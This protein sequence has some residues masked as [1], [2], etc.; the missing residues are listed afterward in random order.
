MSSRAA[1]ERR[2]VLGLGI[3]LVA[4]VALIAAVI[5]QDRRAANDGPVADDG[6]VSRIVIERPG[7]PAIMLERPTASLESGAANGTGWRITAPCALEALDA[8]IEPLLDALADTALDYAADEV[9]LEAAG[10]IEPLAVVRLDGVATSLGGT[11]LGGERRY[12]LRGRRVALVPEWTLS[13][14]EG[15]LSA[16]AD[17]VPL[18]DTPSG[19]RRL[20]G[21]DADAELDPAPWG[22]LAASQI[23]PWPV[24][25]AP[26]PTRRAR[27]E[28]ALSSG[29]TRLLELVGNER[30]NALRVDGGSCAYL[31]VDD[32][33]PPA[34]FGTPEVPESER[35][36]Q[37]DR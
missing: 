18:L 19:L 35:T 4:L 26:P 10:L 11:D 33:L 28:A 29:E 17:P 23:V 7:Q 2:L 16:F 27:L 37:S 32:E 30:W 22:E 9:D 3:G 14:V 24:A 21:P 34:T 1:R 6:T 31:F 20:E 13:L 15:G 5:V 8:R 36:E 25:D 12:A